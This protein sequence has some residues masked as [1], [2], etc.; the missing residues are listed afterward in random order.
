[1][2]IEHRLRSFEVVSPKA[3]GHFGAERDDS[4]VCNAFAI[5]P[6]ASLG[7]HAICGADQDSGIGLRHDRP[8]QFEDAPGYSRA[9]TLRFRMSGL[10]P[11]RLLRCDM[12]ALH[13]LLCLRGLSLWLA[14]LGE[15]SKGLDSTPSL[16]PL[17]ALD[18]WSSVG[19]QYVLAFLLRGGV[20]LYWINYKED[21]IDV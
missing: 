9:F 11:P 2:L 6:C 5:Q 8:E 17:L 19:Q 13:P 10:R 18:K 3:G 21:S 12:D 7:C 4:T 15:P 14:T 1:M 16:G 20:I